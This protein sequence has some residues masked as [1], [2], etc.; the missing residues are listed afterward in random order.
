MALVKLFK[1]VL[2][3][4]TPKHFEPTAFDQG[5]SGFFCQIVLED[6]EQIVSFW[7]GVEDGDQ[8]GEAFDVEGYE[9]EKAKNFR[10]AA[11]EWQG[12][13]KYTFQPTY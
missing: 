1:G 7:A 3:Q 13:T 6:G 9:V 12:K 2:I 8:L 11:K 5:R 4:K 10:L